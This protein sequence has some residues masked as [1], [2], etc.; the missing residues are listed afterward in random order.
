DFLF[1]TIKLPVIYN[2]TKMNLGIMFSYQIVNS[3]QNSVNY[4]GG[5]FKI[6]TR[7]KI[8][9]NE[10]YLMIGSGLKYTSGYHFYSLDFW[11]YTEADKTLEFGVGIAYLNLLGIEYQHKVYNK[12]GVNEHFNQINQGCEIYFIEH[13]PLRF[14]YSFGFAAPKYSY[15]F[16]ELESIISAGFGIYPIDSKMRIDISARLRFYKTDDWW[17]TEPYIGI[18]FYLTDRVDYLR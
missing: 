8:K 16:N 10:K 13:H 1:H 15:Y 2:D 9:F 4:D 5:L 6:Q 18:S 3:F 14:G 11:R 17:H 12:D 7:R